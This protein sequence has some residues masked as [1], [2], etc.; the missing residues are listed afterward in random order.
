MD[1]R[2]VLIT[3]GS[4]LLVVRRA[5]AQTPAKPPRVAVL[6][7]GFAG[8][9][10]SRDGQT[11]FE[12]GL[13]ELGWTPGSTI[14][15]EY[16]WADNNHEQ[17]ARHVAELVRSVPAVIVVRTGVAQQAVTRATT[18]IPIVLGGATDPVAQGFR[19]EP[20]PAWWQCH[21][22]GPS[23]GRTAPQADRAPEGGGTEAPALRTAGRPHYLIPLTP[24]VDRAARVLGLEVQHVT[25]ST[26]EELPLA[27]ST[28]SRGRSGAVVVHAD[29][30]G[31]LDREI[32]RVVSPAATHRL[33]AI[34][35]WRQHV[36]AGGLMAFAVDI[37]DI[38]RQTARFVD[39]I[40]KGTKPSDI[41][42]EQPTKF[43]LVINLSTARNLALTIPQ[44]LLHRADRLIK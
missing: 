13:R 33:P 12:T 3:L 10:I 21:R 37:A 31:P 22:P 8:G 6:S 34:Y 18:T 38:Q 28:I 5:A 16:R 9:Q 27:F 2:V 42:V 11:A 19:P 26:A 35:A 30:A 43:E 32:T 20:P 1:R 17:L 24:G 4:C 36:E 15:V 41:P 14:A 40:L 25:I 44:S 39:K 23:T 29:G 7:F